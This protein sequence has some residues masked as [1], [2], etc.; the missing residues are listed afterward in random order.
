M[1]DFPYGDRKVRGSR[2]GRPLHYHVIFFEKK[3]HST[4]SL[5]GVNLR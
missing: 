4:L 5:V 2:V 1:P 3:V